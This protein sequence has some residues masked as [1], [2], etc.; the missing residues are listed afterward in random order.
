MWNGKAIVVNTKTGKHFSNSPIP[1]EKAKAQLRV[2]KQSES[3]EMKDD[4][5]WSGYK[6]IGTKKKGKRTVPNCVP[7]D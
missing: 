6:M 1:I 4:P 7:E 2:L 5:C 3:K